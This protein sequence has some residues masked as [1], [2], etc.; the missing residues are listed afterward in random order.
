MTD[1]K[2]VPS[3]TNQGPINPLLPDQ[4]EALKAVLRAVYQRTQMHL[5]DTGLK[6][7]AT[8]TLHRATA[9]VFSAAR[10]GTTVDYQSAALTSFTS[11][12]EVADSWDNARAVLTAKVPRTKVL[13]INNVFLQGGWMGEE[14]EVILLGG[15]IEVKV[16]QPNPPKKDDD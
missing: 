14:S 1:A 7:D 12:R 4:Y 5:A 2:E 3:Y 9:G 13:F 10:F 11:D 8:V 6:E 15:K 16:S